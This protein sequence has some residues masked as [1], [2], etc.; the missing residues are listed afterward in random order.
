[1]VRKRQP[2]SDHYFETAAKFLTDERMLADL[3]LEERFD[4]V[5]DRAL[6][7]LFSL[8]MADQLEGAS[9]ARIVEFKAA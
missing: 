8:K 9:K 6:K 1:M 2:E 4:A 7:R 5:M 3:E